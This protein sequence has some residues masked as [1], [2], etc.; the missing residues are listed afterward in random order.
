[1]LEKRR[2]T[3]AHLEEACG[4]WCKVYLCSDKCICCPFIGHQLFTVDFSVPKF[5]PR[6]THEVKLDLS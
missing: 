3:P 2:T 4:I 5:K 1:M 6:R